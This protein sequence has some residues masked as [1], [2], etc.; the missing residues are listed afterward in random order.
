MC[1]RS[2]DGEPSEACV[3][4]FGG[5]GDDSS[6]DS[7]NDAEEDGS[8]ADE[9]QSA[10][11]VPKLPSPFLQASSKLP[12][13]LLKPG[14]SQTPSYS[15]GATS[16]V[17]VNPFEQ[18]EQAKLGILEKHVRLTEAAPKKPA[19][20]QVCFKFRKGT[21]HLG[22]K[23]RFFHDR[24]NIALG[25]VRDRSDSSVTSETEQDS[26]P[27]FGRGDKSFTFPG[28][29]GGTGGHVRR[30]G[31]GGGDGRFYHPAAQFSQGQPADLRSLDEDNYM[32]SA[33]GRK[34]CG[35]TDHLVPPKKA[36]MGLDDLR[37]KER[38]WTTKK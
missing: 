33:R 2:A 28:H 38:P 37:K 23:C 11:Q 15:A 5:D 14:E 20:K 19:S 4:F 10:E 7:N 25:G 3:N 35:V 29:G 21:C 16:S 8:K 32:N 31:G 36:L 22:A 13:P 30:G 17:F 27:G 6:E 18:A 1:F 26:G 24:S 34:R 9:N 12:A